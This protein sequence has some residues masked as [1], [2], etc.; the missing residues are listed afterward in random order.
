ME[1]YQY[2][3]RFRTYNKGKKTI[4]LKKNYFIF[5]ILKT[6]EIISTTVYFNFLLRHLTQTKHMGPTEL[7]SKTSFLMHSALHQYM[8]R[9]L[10]RASKYRNLYTGNLTYIFFLKPKRKKN[11]STPRQ[12]RNA[13]KRHKPQKISTQDQHMCLKSTYQSTIHVTNLHYKKT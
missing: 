12:Y 3:L 9:L 1:R 10:N 13:T 5:T 8:P 6:K 11:I 4:P 2:A 7:H